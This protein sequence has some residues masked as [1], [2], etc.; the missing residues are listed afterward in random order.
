[1]RTFYCI[2][3]TEKE[4]AHSQIHACVLLGVVAS[5]SI[6]GNVGWI[7]HEALDLDICKRQS[8]DSVALQC[9]CPCVGGNIQNLL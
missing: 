8:D 9:D 6:D 7:Q 1:M 2:H 5:S 3:N 4:L